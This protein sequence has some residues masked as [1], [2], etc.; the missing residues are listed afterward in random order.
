MVPAEGLL[1]RALDALY[2]VMAGRVDWKSKQQMKRE[3]LVIPDSEINI[4]ANVQ[5]ACGPYEPA[6]Q[7]FGRLQAYSYL[8]SHQI[9]THHPQV[10]QHEQRTQPLGALRQASV[11]HLGVAEL[12]L[13]HP[14]RV[15]NLGPGAGLD[16]LNLLGQASINCVRSSSLRLPGRMTLF[17]HT[18]S[19]AS[20][21]LPAPWQPPSPYASF[22]RP[23]S[24]VLT[25][26]TS[27]T[28]SASRRPTAS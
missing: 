17:Q 4:R 2:R 28:L 10:G 7:P 13:D 26:T 21:R 3:K 15:L 25:S 24:S 22:S 1:E 27:L 9:S 12:A 6:L 8:P 23:C 20:G 19:L 16:A 5:A 11:S 14:K 18:P